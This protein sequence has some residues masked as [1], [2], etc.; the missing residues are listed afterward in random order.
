MLVDMPDATLREKILKAVLSDEALSPNFDFGRLA[1]DDVTGGFSGSDLKNMCIAAAY[2]PIREIITKES[3]QKK[4]PLKSSLSLQKVDA[5]KNEVVY[6][7]DLGEEEVE[8]RNLHLADFEAAAKEIGASTS[9]D[10]FTMQEIRKWNEM[11]G[12]RGSR[13]KTVLSYFT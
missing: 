6:E 2:R 1:R 10:S 7:E 3:K 12:E 4:S 5:S 11:Y 8:L 13:K 9:E